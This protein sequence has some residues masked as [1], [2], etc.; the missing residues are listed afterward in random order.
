MIS[1]LFFF[2]VHFPCRLPP[3]RCA[4][5]A[6]RLS[7]NPPSIL[8]FFLFSLFLSSQRRQ[9]HSH[10]PTAFT[11]TSDPQPTAQPVFN[12]SCIPS[13]AFF[14]LFSLH[15]LSSLYPRQPPSLPS[16]QCLC[17]SNR[18]VCRA[19]PLHSATATAPPALAGSLGRDP[20]HAPRLAPDVIAIARGIFLYS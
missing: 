17:T 20:L 13:S 6:P 7:N 15:F 16:F 3:T 9:Q 12:S 11:S 1:W 18:A 8:P 2:A 4:G 5:V 19:T 10:S 14:F